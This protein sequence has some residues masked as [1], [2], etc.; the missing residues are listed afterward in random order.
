MQVQKTSKFVDFT[1]AG[2]ESGLSKDLNVFQPTFAQTDRP[3][4]QMPDE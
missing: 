4:K 2:A 1:N 3:K